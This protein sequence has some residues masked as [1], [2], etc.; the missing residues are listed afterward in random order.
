MK[1]IVFFINLVATLLELDY[2]NLLYYIHHHSPK[3]KLAMRARAQSRINR[4]AS[5]TY[6][7]FHACCLRY[8]WYV[9]R[10]MTLRCVEGAQTDGISIQAHL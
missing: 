8:S 6:Q 3:K 7:G 1:N 9:Y 4:V 5:I 10:M 2:M